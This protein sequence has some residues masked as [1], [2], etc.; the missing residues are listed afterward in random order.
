MHPRTSWIVLG[1]IA[2]ITAQAGTIFKWTDADGVVHYSDQPH[3]GATAV[4]TSGSMSTYS[5]STASGANRGATPPPAP[6][7]KPQGEPGYQ[8]LALSAPA[9]EQSFFNDDPVNAS[10]AL[11]PGLKE[12]QT[13]TWHLNG[14]PLP[15]EAPTAT[16]IT[17]PRLARGE[18]TVSATVNDVATGETWS[19]EAV[20]FFV[21]QPSAL[22]PQSRA[23]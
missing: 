17:L 7:Q 23:R 8:I 16:Q 22:S 5:G 14:A 13:V 9:K 21:K 2:A 20:T 11:S 1:L 6:P 19:T 4:Q 18:Y 3:P 12:G 15:D 10:L